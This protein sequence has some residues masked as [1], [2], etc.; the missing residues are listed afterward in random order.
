MVSYE[1]FYCMFSTLTCMLCDLLLF[2]HLCRDTAGQER[3]Q[4]ITKQYY[5][6]AQVIP[7]SIWTCFLYDFLQPSFFNLPSWFLV[8]G[9][10]FVYD[11]TS[12]PSF[13]HIVK[14]ASDVD[15]VRTISTLICPSHWPSICSTSQ[16]SAAQPVAQFEWQDDEVPYLV[17]LSVV[18]VLQYAPDK[19]QRIL[20][21]NKSDEELRRQVTQDQGIKVRLSLI[22]W[23][24]LGFFGCIFSCNLLNNI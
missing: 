10:I 5:R 1:S 2:Y 13:Q 11:I 6:R 3:Y 21:G 16:C 9:I 15:E 12:E 22:F 14:W 17:C 4:T 24:L 23:V 7:R 20:V 19:V 8:Q 18:V